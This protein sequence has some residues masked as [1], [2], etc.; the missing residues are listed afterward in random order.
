MMSRMKVV[1]KQRRMKVHQ[2]LSN[3]FN[4]NVQKLSSHF[5]Y[6][7]FELTEFCALVGHMPSIIIYNNCIY[8]IFVRP[9]LSFLVSSNPE[10]QPSWF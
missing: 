8:N 9:D 4:D 6:N 10:C 7:P 1:P 2:L 3:R 5:V